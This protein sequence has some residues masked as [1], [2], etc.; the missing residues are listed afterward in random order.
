MA[1]TLYTV[2]Y[3]SGEDFFLFK[4]LDGAQ[5]NGTEHRALEM[6]SKVLLKAYLVKK[7]RKRILFLT[8]VAS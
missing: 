4:Q 1:S 7:K 3:H 5:L 2:I 6:F 8:G